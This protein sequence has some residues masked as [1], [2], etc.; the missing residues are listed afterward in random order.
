M[1]LAAAEVGG[2]GC[3]VALADNFETPR[4]ET[5]GAEIQLNR[6]P[7]ASITKYPKEKP[8]NLGQM[9]TKVSIFSI[10]NGKPEAK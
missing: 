1:Q 8:P 5:I 10:S 3:A 7:N 6:E 4:G 9:N 2:G